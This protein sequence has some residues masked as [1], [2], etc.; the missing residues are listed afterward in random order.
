MS[1]EKERGVDMTTTA[2]KWGNSLGIR[3]AKPIAEEVG[4]QDGTELTYRVVDGGIFVKP[5]KR[6][7]TLDDLLKKITPEN[8]HADLFPD[9]EGDE[10]L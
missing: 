1:K 4:I 6:K 7:P 5:V 10:L 9:T 2:K 3:L 8:R